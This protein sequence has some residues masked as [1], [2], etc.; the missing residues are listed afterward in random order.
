MAPQQ[1]TQARLSELEARAEKCE[2]RFQVMQRE[3]QIANERMDEI[4]N[5][6]R[7]LLSAVFGD[8]N[9]PHSKPGI[10]PRLAVIEQRQ[11]AE[12]DRI[13]SEM[14]RMEEK[15]GDTNKILNEMR[16]DIRRMVWIVLGSV[17]ASL[18]TLILKH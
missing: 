1:H 2:V 15:I 3:F 6:Q 12:A 11:V 8:M 18:M 7:L 17:V 16:T 4:K 13:K 9:E 5:Q 14:L 10:I